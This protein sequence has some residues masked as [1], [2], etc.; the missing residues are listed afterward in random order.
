MQQIEQAAAS[1]PLG[2]SFTSQGSQQ[3]QRSQR[4][5]AVVPQGLCTCQASDSYYIAPNLCTSHVPIEAGPS[6]MAQQVGM[7]SSQT[8]SHIW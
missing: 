4:G 5:L 8:D 2:R 3:L 7:H 6:N 1:Q